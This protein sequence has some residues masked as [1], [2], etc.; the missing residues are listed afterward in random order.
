MQTTGIFR[1]PVIVGELTTIEPLLIESVIR[2]E[3]KRG[4]SSKSPSDKTL[5]RW[6]YEDRRRKFRYAALDLV[7]RKEAEIV[8]RKLKKIREGKALNVHSNVR[9]RD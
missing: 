2:N 4:P 3:R 8:H 7:T 9:S 6:R 1:N 5:R